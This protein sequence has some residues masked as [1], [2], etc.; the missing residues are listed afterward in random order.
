MKRS[1]F[2]LLLS[3]AA[4]DATHSVRDG[5]PRPA[6]SDAGSSDTAPDRG[7]SAGDPSELDAG[8]QGPDAGT[9][10]S[11]ASALDADAS[12]TELDASD[13]AMDDAGDDAAVPADS[14]TLTR[15]THGVVHVRARDLYG[16]GYGVAYTY[17]LDNR[18]LLA[19]RIAEVNGRLSAEL[20]ADAPVRSEVHDITYTAL[21]SDHYYR[22][23][24]DIAAIRAGFDAGAPEVRE[25]AAGY[26]RG[27]TRAFAEGSAACEV[28]VP[29]SVSID[30]V[31]RMWVATAAVGSGEM[32]ASFLPRAKPSA[33]AA[34]TTPRAL[35]KK[36]DAVGSNAWALGREATRAGGSVHLYNPHFPWAGIQRLYLVHVTVPGALDVMGPVLGGFP[37]PLAGFNHDV[38]WG[39]TFSPAARWTAFE[40]A[41]TTPTTYRLDG[42]AKT[43][44]EDVL[45]IPVRGEASPRRV[46]FYRAE[47]G[48]LIDAPDFGLGWSTSQAFA[49][50]DVNA[51]NTRMVEQTLRIAQAKSVAELESALASVQGVPWSYTLASDRAGD[52][53]FGDV[54]N[55]PAVS[56]ADVSRCVTTLTGLVL[57]SS[58]FVVLDGTRA[59]CIWQGHMA[60]PQ[61]PRARRSDYVANSN[62]NYELPNPAA[63]LSGFS[64][65][66]GAT[67]RALGL[68][69]SLGLHMIADRL[70]GSDGLGAAGFSGELAKRVLLSDRNRAA[71]LLVDGVVADCALF[72]SADVSGTRVDLGPACGVLSRW[73]RKNTPSSKGAALFRGVWMQLSDRAGLFAT[74]ASLDAPLTTPSGYTLSPFT[75]AA[76]RTALATV[77]R[78]FAQRSI[79]LDV[80]WGDVNRVRRGSVSYGMPGGLD[81]EG[82]FDVATGKA[83][84][85]TYQGWLD[86][87]PGNAPETLYGASYFHSVE[88]AGSGEPVAQ[89]LLAYSQ[90][91]EPS[92]PYYDDQLSDWSRQAWFTLPFSA[93]QIAADPARVSQDLTVQR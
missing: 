44:G 84:Y 45:E 57:L 70:A 74:A 29:E 93:A 3:L 34:V 19:R 7:D 8:A 76:V 1:V 63:R 12:N 36:L 54:S 66:L 67:G 2:P 79:P 75:R 92:S 46:P 65:V 18:C 51:T 62:N 10:A 78:D 39:L 13:G 80:S 38:A 49:V 42:A 56:S 72:D 15:T 40:L 21:Q 6:D 11:D 47:Q 85:Y 9:S 87:I 33:S 22:G 53:F 71:E 5:G 16:A 58:G 77:V 60:A 64:P 25:L 55:V 27:A 91:T 20:G 35:P 14:L 32:L 59:D 82:L 52:V 37:L 4:C 41:L 73:D 86:S 31:Y 23:W 90:A 50:K 61:Q 68:R 83:G 69:A 89:G 24:F 26:A 81:A 17:T 30:D 43:I 88:L 28:S 48:P